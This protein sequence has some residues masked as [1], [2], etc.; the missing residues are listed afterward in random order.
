MYRRKL[1]NF[2]SAVSTVLTASTPHRQ[3]SHNPPL[4]L[5]RAMQTLLRHQDP[6]LLVMKTFIKG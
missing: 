3:S 2:G 4:N 5:N 6:G 1:G